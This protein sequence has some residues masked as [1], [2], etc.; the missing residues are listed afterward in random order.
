MLEELSIYLKGYREM[1]EIDAEESD[2]YKSDESVDEVE[3]IL[4]S[5]ISLSLKIDEYADRWVRSI[6]DD[7]ESEIRLPEH[8]AKRL[9]RQVFYNYLSFG[10]SENRGNSA[11]SLNNRIQD[12]K[13]LIKSLKS[14]IKIT[15]RNNMSFMFEIDDMV[16][17]V[18]FIKEIQGRY[19]R[20]AQQTPKKLLTR[21]SMDGGK[22]P[23]AMLIW[24]EWSK[25]HWER[26]KKEEQVDARNHKAANI[27]ING[28]LKFL[29]TVQRKKPSIAECSTI[30]KY[31]D[32]KNI[33]HERTRKSVHRYLFIKEGLDIIKRSLKDR[34]NR[35]KIRYEFKKI[36][37]DSDDSTLEL[38]K[39]KE[40]P[41]F[42]DYI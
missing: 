25:Q 36:D 8:V 2:Y 15:R 19:P 10:F 9:L 3:L 27:L 42:D 28:L 18:N 41:S 13:D 6:I 24:A 21:L 31:K 12:F 22:V 32:D 34:Q 23:A 5:D 26:K 7:T 11:E 39:F 20:E 35:E 30:I 1:S 37:W 14:V 17:D 4:K 29:F 33:S 16:N 38:L 40:D